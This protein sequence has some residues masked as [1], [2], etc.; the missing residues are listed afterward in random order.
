M[1]RRISPSRHGFPPSITNA[2]YSA[3]CP[4]ELLSKV[5]QWYG[6]DLL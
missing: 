5:N 4:N 1:Q 3:V 2:A 6:G